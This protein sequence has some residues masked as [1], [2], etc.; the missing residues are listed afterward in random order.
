MRPSAWLSALLSKND[1]APAEVD[2]GKPPVVVVH[3]IYNNGDS[4]GRIVR[5]LQA[6]GREAFAPSL[7]PSSGRAPLE[8]L[9]LQLADYIEANVQRRPFDLV[10]FSMGGL[11]TRHYLQRRGGIKNV[12]RYITLAAPHHGT[13][14]AWLNFGAG[15]HQM[16][17]N[18]E[19]VQ[20][21]NSDADVLR[22]IPFTSFWT[23]TDLMIVPASSSVMP[24]A[25]N[26]RLSG[27][28][29]ASF[30]L[31]KR[32]IDHIVQALQ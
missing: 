15:T 7:T 5:A 27:L 11:I 22:Q 18:S 31:E 9:S 30:L 24:Q 21:L 14:M 1:P 17:R 6:D 4:M 32:F 12:R 28:G 25:T 10:G 19:F 26:I 2:L 13:Q 3:G 29:H 8:A 20:D 16:H 23:W